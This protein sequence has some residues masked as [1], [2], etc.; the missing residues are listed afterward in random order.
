MNDTKSSTKEEQR[1]MDVTILGYLQELMDVSAVEAAA[2]MP[3]M[4][5]RRFEKKELIITAGEQEDYLNLVISGLVRKFICKGN[6]E[7]TLQLATE[8]HIV[9]SEISYLRR[10]PSV[11][12]LE[13]LE[14][15]LLLSLS[16]DHM[17]YALDHLPGADRM[18]RMLI[19]CMLLKKDERQ[20]KQLRLSTRQRFIDYLQNHPHMLQRVPQK[21]LASYLNIKPETFSRLKHLLKG[22]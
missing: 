11:V 2:L 20:F 10:E 4:E 17:Q 8:G 16:H 18:G 13:A 21:Y 22:K 7:Y 3:L 15:T 9:H 1:P 14:P 12:Q 19:T 5:W 6:N